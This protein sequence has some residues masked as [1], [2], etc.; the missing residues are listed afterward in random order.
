V[1]KTVSRQHIR[2]EVEDVGATGCTKHLV[3]SRITL[4]DLNTKIGTLVNG[5]QIRGRKYDLT[6]VENVVA[7]GKYKSHFT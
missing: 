6:R 5:E 4:E 7:V 1:D 2:V 3:R